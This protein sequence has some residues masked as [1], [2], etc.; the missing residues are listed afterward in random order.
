VNIPRV[1]QP[2]VQQQ[3]GHGGTA[4][5]APATGA[6]GAVLAKFDS[7]GKCNTQHGTAVLVTKTDGQTRF[8]FPK[9]EHAEYWTADKRDAFTECSLEEQYFL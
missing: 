3:Q 8:I 5:A 7:D 9:E 2:P 1:A 6:H 4:R